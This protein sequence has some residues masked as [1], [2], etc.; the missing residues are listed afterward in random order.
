MLSKL[1]ELELTRN[2][3][4]RLF[5]YGFALTVFETLSGAYLFFI[6][7][8]AA[9]EMTLLLLHLLLGFAFAIPCVSFLYRHLQYRRLFP[10]RRYSV[11]GFGAL[12]GMLFSLGSGAYLTFTGITGHAVMWWLHIA[13]SFLCVAALAAYLGMT[14]RRFARSVPPQSLPFLRQSVVRIGLHISAATALIFAAAVSVAF[15]YQEPDPRKTVPNY[16]YALGVDNPFAP[17]GLTT[18]TGGFLKEELFLGSKSCGTAGCHADSLKQWQ[19]SVHYR[20]PNTVSTVVE[21]LLIRETKQHG[22]ARGYLQID[23][24]RE[25]ID[26][27]EN[28]RFCAACHA[29]VALL[30]GNV[31]PGQPQ[32]SFEK[33]E[34]VSCI[35]C[36]SIVS[37]STTGGVDYTIA[38]PRRYLFA[39]S[40]S[41]LG[42]FVHRTLISNKPG[43]H[44][45]AFMKPFY[46]ESAYCSVCHNRLHYPYWRTSPYNDPKAPRD[47]MSC[48]NCHM[49]QI[50]SGDDVSAAAKGTVTDH[51][52]LGGNML[53]PLIYG[54]KTQSLLTE[55]FLKNSVMALQIVAPE[56]ASPG[57]ELEFAVRLANAKVGHIFPAGPEADLM[58]AWTE[59][60]ARTDDGKVLFRYGMLDAKGHLDDRKTYVYRI[61]PMGANSKPLELDRHRSW[62]FAE[63]RL[64]VIP[65]RQYDETFFR[66]K[67]PASAL[68]RRIRLQAKL[69]FRKHNQGFVDWIVG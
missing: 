36:H 64:Q 21:N 29:P 46:R 34:G 13:V 4:T 6:T 28:F 39:H 1:R 61:Y 58:E 11:T 45:R 37:V 15:F 10:D 59:V 12:L 27:R 55:R 30:S 53:V 38:P 14:V 60:T 24:L 26:G 17:S 48:Q 68:S 63:D 3:G 5:R 49:P 52:T 50:P 23:E 32:E 33:F 47:K 20:S 22:S 2:W 9:W 67:V 66:F 56:T 42:Q 35:A 7:D 54:L 43:S 40:R 65:P 19:D 51:R 16:S 25:Q 41:E 44:K 57:A 8:M 69:R 31:N 62:M 18:S